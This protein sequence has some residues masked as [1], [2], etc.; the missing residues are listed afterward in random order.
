MQ[1]FRNGG[2]G[3]ESDGRGFGS[4]P[5]G[6]Q[7]SPTGQGPSMPSAII[8]GAMGGPNGGFDATMGGM[9][10]RGMNPGNN[11]GMGDQP[12]QY[13]E[14]M[15]QMQKQCMAGDGYACNQLQLMQQQ[16]QQQN[17]N[18]QQ[19]YQQNRQRYGNTMPGTPGQNRWG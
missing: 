14:A 19:G 9:P 4:R 2:M 16:N 15:A 1:N 12:P 11:F 3:M 13:T 10:M 5:G 6:G 8:G 7:M 18:W 17:T